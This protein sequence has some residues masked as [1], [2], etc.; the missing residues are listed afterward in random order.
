MQAIAS[1]LLNLCNLRNLWIFISSGSGLKVRNDFIVGS[2]GKPAPPSCGVAVGVEYDRVRPG[3]QRAA[4]RV[5]PAIETEGL[6]NS[7]QEGILFSKSEMDVTADAPG[8]LQLT[9][10]QR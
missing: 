7:L 8:W 10:N 6:P 5:L 9:K 1:N 3:W 4:R 2:S